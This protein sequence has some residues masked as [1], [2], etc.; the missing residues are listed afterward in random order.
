VGVVRAIVVGPAGTLTWSF[1]PMRALALLLVVVLAILLVLKFYP[2]SEVEGGVGETEAPANPD[3]FRDQFLT[4]PGSDDEPVS[5]TPRAT[6]PPAATTPQ[7]DP[8]RVPRTVP[9]AT[10]RASSGPHDAED[11]ALGAML[12][13]GTPDELSRLLEAQ[14]I[15]GDRR[16]CLS[17][18]A[19]ALAGHGERAAN[20]AAR[21]GDES[22]LVAGERQALDVAI[23]GSGIIP[24][25]ASARS[26]GVVVLAMRMSLLA[27]QAGSLVESGDFPAAARD[28]S[29][30]LLLEADAPWPSD[31]RLLDDWSRGLRVAQRNHRWNPRGQSRSPALHRARRARQSAARLHPPRRRAQD[32]HGSRERDRG[33]ELALG[34]VSARE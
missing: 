10:R 27:R 22:A 12:L 18:F 11:A 19:E 24:R 13:H 20:L 8:V 15:E 25:A 17:A 23:G 16:L 5:T 34:A 30:L 21:I 14:G 32:P 4:D 9:A 7:D 26:E 2:S 6:T 1:H 3:A 31:R 29:E 28:F 33:P